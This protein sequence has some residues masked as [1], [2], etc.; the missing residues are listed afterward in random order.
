MGEPTTGVVRFEISGPIA[1]VT[2]DRPEARNA[3][4]REVFALAEHA[5]DRIA[6][7]PAIRVLVTGSAGE[8]A[9]AP[10][11]TWTSSVTSRRLATE[12]GMSRDDGGDLAGTT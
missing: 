5:L 9:S 4:N 11:P 8:R 12:R 7:D 1:F 2:I 10:E 3:L 6:D